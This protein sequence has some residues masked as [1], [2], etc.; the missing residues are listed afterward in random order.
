[1]VKFRHDYK[2]S[3]LTNQKKAQG[4][5]FCLARSL[6]DQ[7]WHEL[8]K[9]S[10]NFLTID[11]VRHTAALQK[12]QSQNLPALFRQRNHYSVPALAKLISLHA[13]HAAGKKQ[14]E[15]AVH[16]AELENVRKLFADKFA[17]NKDAHS[18]Q[19]DS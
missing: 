3:L 8:G 6:N 18:D 7:Q 19:G 9:Y 16:H 2:Q 12:V 11:W 4:Q 13:K 17:H 15:S 14:I 10:L 1:M 5:F